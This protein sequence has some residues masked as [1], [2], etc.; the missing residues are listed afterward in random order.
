M[1]F[2]PG[3]KW[4]E[5]VG[6]YRTISGMKA[7][8]K[9]IKDV[10]VPVGEEAGLK[11]KDRVLANVEAMLKAPSMGV[12]PD[13]VIVV[14][15]SD[16][17]ADFW[18]KRL[19]GQDG[20]HGSGTIVK[21][22][23]VV[24][25]VS[26]S[27]WH[28]SAG[29]GLGTINAFYMAGK[30]ALRLGLIG[31]GKDDL[32]DIL[33][34][35]TAFS[36]HKSV[37]MFHTAGKGT[38][39][40]PLTAAE[41][42]SKSRIKLPGIVE[43]KKGRETITVLELVIRAAAIY[44]PTREG[45]V[46]VFWGDQVL[47]NEFDVSSDGRYHIE[48]FAQPVPLDESIKSYGIIIP[49]KD[50]D[51]L[52]REKLPVSRVR[53]MFP[54]LSDRVYRSV[55]SFS[56]SLDLFERLVVSEKQALISREGALNTDNDWW[57]ALTSTIEEYAALSLEKG[58]PAVIAGERWR[59][60]RKVCDE[61][62]SGGKHGQGSERMVGFKDTGENSLWMDYGRNS[63]LFENILLLTG[64]SSAALQA[65]TFFGLEVESGKGLTNTGAAAENSVIVN[66]RLGAGNVKNCVIVS[67]DIEEVNAVDSVIIGSDIIKLNSV[68]ALCYNVVSSLED[69]KKGDILVNVF[70]PEKGAIEMRTDISRNGQADWEDGT[71]I[72]E[73]IFSYPELSEVIR[74]V[75]EQDMLKAREIA[76]SEIRKERKNNG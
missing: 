20:V 30:M 60:T 71:K 10:P 65:R 76:F 13:M 61:F 49:G 72:G 12:G 26:E 59:K 58:I 37:F 43:T 63:C 25:S 23:A 51:C 38:R 14:S 4:L 70:H 64:T 68:G 66:S 41:H 17:G 55:G 3:T 52:V 56:L 19:T 45:R 62:I 69:L 47:L 44:A 18:Q 53:E 42:N 75:S 36:R 9:K 29:N 8:E 39:L 40:S 27:N 2:A 6:C 74:K 16:A 48:I 24:L 34:L 32:D 28:G 46:S 15:S 11:S 57:Q 73:N 7:R 54:E 31:P 1:N 21:T 22:S 33:N 5:K 35:F 67:S 50:G